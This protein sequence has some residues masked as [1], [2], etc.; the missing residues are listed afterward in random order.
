MGFVHTKLRN[1]LAPQTVEKLIYIKS[2]YAAFADNIYASEQSD[3]TDGANS[4]E[5]EEASDNEVVEHIDY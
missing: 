1:S 5:E 3:S 2:N 4:S